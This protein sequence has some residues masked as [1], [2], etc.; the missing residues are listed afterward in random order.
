MQEE[1]R[2]V[3]LALFSQ[4]NLTVHLGFDQPQLADTNWYQDKNHPY[5]KAIAQILDHLVTW[6]SIKRLEF[7]IAPGC[8]PM[9][10][11]QIKLNRQRFPFSSKP[12]QLFS[13]LE[14]QTIY[15]FSQI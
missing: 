4:P 15:S 5:L 13:N 7:L 6:L 8:D 11:L 14:T 10:S 2:P 3:A 9:T 1:A 12:S